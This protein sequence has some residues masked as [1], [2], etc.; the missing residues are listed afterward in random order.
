MGS[1][2]DMINGRPIRNLRNPDYVNH[3]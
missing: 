2:E 3:R 1:I